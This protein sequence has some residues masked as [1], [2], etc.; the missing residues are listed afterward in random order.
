MELET[1]LD[2]PDR[3]TVNW[4]AYFESRGVNSNDG[5]YKLVSW[6]SI[7]VPELRK[8]GWYVPED[9]NWTYINSNLIKSQYLDDLR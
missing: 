3:V 6:F 8:R 4:K 2:H 7:I 5:T 9:I 1:N